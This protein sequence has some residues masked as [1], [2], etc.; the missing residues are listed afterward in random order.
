[1]VSNSALPRGA[2]TPPLTLRTWHRCTVAAAH[3]VAR[4]TVI[5]VAVVKD[6]AESSVVMHRTNR[7]SEQFPLVVESLPGSTNGF[8]D[9]HSRRRHVELLHRQPVTGFLHEEL[10]LGLGGTRYHQRA[11]HPWRGYRK[12]LPRSG[13]C[14]YREKMGGVGGGVGVV[15]WIFTNVFIEHNRTKQWL[16][17]CTPGSNA[18]SVHPARSHPS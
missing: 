2:L 16:G 12:S 6:D 1:M 11:C 7:P 4:T 10:W 9:I 14:F 13:G 15:K 18:A 5:M 3:Q 8:T 17:S